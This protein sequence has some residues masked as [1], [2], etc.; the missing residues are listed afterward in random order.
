M[1]ANAT[2]LSIDYIDSTDYDVLS[3]K[4]KDLKS[5]LCD[6]TNDSIATRKLRYTEID[7]E[8]ERKAGRLAPDEMYVASHIIDTNIRREQSSYIQYITQSPRAVILKDLQDAAFDLSLLEQDLTSKLRF[9]GWQLGSYANIDGFQ[10]NG[11]G[12]CETIQDINNPGHIGREYVQYGDLAFIS[13]TRDL[14]ACEFIARQYYFNK[15]KLLNLTKAEKPEDKWNKEQVDKILSQNPTNDTPVINYT[16]SQDKS[17]Y[18]IQKIM[19]RVK[20]V[21][22]VA[23]CCHGICDDW[24]R[25]PRPLFLGRRKINQK[26]AKVARFIGK[27][28]AP[29]LQKLVPE[30]TN[31]HVNQVKAGKPPSD[32]DYETQYPYFLYPYLISEN[33]TIMNLKG[34]TFLDQDTQSAVSSMISCTITQAR[35]AAGLYFSRDDA[36]PNSDF[37]MQKNVF[38]KT[39]CLINGKVKEMRIEAPDPSMFSAIQMLVSS[40]QQ[41]TSQVNFAESN[42][43]KDSRKTAKAVEAATQQSQQLSGTQVT[44]YSIALKA[45]YSYEID[46]IKSRVLCGLIDVNPQ[47]F[48]LYQRTFSVKPSGDVDVI[49]KQQL[50][51]TMMQAW[52]VVQNTP[53]AQAFLLKLIE[54]MFPDDAASY[55]S[56][57]QQAQQQ[58]SSQQQ[59]MLQQALQLA[60]RTADGII[61]LSK[62]PEFFSET[63]RVHA[64]PI[65]EQAAEKFEDI[66]QQM[67]GGQKQ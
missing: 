15:T 34:R 61:N 19:F 16:S 42:K 59:Q 56:M 18:K 35:R 60:K 65:V 58:Q 50:V 45:Q 30:L 27:V 2:D 11:Y 64:Y 21:V 43:Q 54:K 28:P 36:D 53:I 12:V 40:N 55:A 67:Q 23:W 7:I 66:M 47:V 1:P 48:P 31:S 57:F 5:L 14:Q 39:G 17:L 8:A 9:D 37:L 13:D 46:I 26:A 24:L 63:G 29:V 6:L 38:F 10:S 33:D 52:A 32:E 49:E 41:E 25:K 22:Q 44:L 3:S 20:G 51:T 62:H 4:I